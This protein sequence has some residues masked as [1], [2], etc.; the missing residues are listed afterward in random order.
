MELFGIPIQTIYLYTLIISGSL[1]IL[2]LFLGDVVEG[3]SEA[4]GFLNPV[5]VL[6][7]LTFMSAIGYLLEAFTG[8]S[9]ILIIVISSIASLILDTLLNVFV[10]IPLANA[11]ESLVYTEDSLKGRIG[12]VI[13]PIPENGFGEV[14]IDSISGRI[15]KP[16]TSFENKEIEEGKKVLVIDVKDG[17]LYV[18]PH[19]QY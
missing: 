5:L 10:L 8:L 1:I 6:A 17:V 9:S 18:V 4:T 13:I 11:E 14:L 12:A 15:S 19:N 3:I 7:F 16:A 2:Y